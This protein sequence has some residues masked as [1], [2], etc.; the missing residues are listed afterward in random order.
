MVKRAAKE[1][2]KSA[3]SHVGHIRLGAMPPKRMT[4]FA[5]RPHQSPQ[6]AKQTHIVSETH[7]SMPLGPAAKK[8]MPWNRSTS[9]TAQMALSHQILAKTKV[10]SAHTRKSVATRRH[11]VAAPLIHLHR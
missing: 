3:T 6:D 1:C 7:R 4:G 2:A 5:T 8:C 9:V 11:G 10:V